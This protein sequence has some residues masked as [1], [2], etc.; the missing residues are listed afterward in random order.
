MKCTIH[1]QEMINVSD[2]SGSHKSC[3]ACCREQC[4][5]KTGEIKS[6]TSIDR[7]CYES[8]P[9]Q[10]HVHTDI[11]T[12]MMTGKDIVKVLQRLSQPIPAHFQ[13]YVEEKL[14]PH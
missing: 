10:H 5:Q 13:A 6:V 9:C 1:N 8:L 11:G 7:T 3:Q 14:Q 2:V 4:Q 12:Y